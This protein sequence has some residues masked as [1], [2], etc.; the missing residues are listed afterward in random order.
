[1]LP[2]RT[3]LFLSSASNFSHRLSKPLLQLLIAGGVP[4]VGERDAEA[5]YRSQ[6]F[7]DA[8]IALE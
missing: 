2:C 8:A 4:K 5:E 3:A 6:V 7:D 1:M